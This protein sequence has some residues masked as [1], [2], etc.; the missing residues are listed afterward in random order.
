[1]PF[2]GASNNPTCNPVNDFSQPQ[3]C[4]FSRSC[5]FPVWRDNYC[6]QHYQTTQ[7]SFSLEGSVAAAC[8]DCATDQFRLVR[9]QKKKRKKE[10]QRKKFERI[11]R[12]DEK[13]FS[14]LGGGQ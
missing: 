7:L 8:I 11:A 13:R 14:H 4:K 12:E 6:R 5:P 9:V 2:I 10:T 1:M 3:S